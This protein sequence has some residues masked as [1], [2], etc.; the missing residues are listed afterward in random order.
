MRQRVRNSDSMPV[1]QRA[2]FCSQE[3]PTTA[4]VRAWKRGGAVA[5]RPQGIWQKTC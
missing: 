1:K 3:H 5:G 4:Q 2:I